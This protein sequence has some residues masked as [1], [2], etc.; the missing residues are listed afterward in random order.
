MVALKIK[1]EPSMMS[2]ADS[3]NESN[4]CMWLETTLCSSSAPEN[5]LPETTIKKMPTIKY[6]NFFTVLPSVIYKLRLQWPSALPEVEKANALMTSVT[7]FGKCTT[8]ARALHTESIT[9]EAKFGL[10]CKALQDNVLI[11]GPDMRL[12][13]DAKSVKINITY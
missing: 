5:T 3:G 1:S 12:K 2:H 8:N 7:T 4:N 10:L 13:A 11:L 6:A 9:Y